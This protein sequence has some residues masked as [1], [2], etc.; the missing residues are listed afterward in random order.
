[1]ST[2]S[3]THS[4]EE[5]S[6]DELQP[7]DL[8]TITDDGTYYLDAVGGKFYEPGLAEESN[9]QIAKDEKAEIVAERLRKGIEHV[10]EKNPKVNVRTLKKKLYKRYN[11]AVKEKK[12][13]VITKYNHVG[14]YVGHDE[15]GNE[16]WVHCTGGRTKTV[17]VNKGCFN[18]YYKLEF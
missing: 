9:K 2:L 15:S 3:I 10:K 8:G 12:Y 11:N 1:M 18:H 7:G 17:V 13:D 5:I 6:H 4:L 16:M 14:I